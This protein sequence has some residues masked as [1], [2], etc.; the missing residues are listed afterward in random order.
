MPGIES[1]DSPREASRAALDLL[2]RKV[3]PS[4]IH[5]NADNSVP[6]W[7]AIDE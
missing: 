1:H 3:K 6:V 2:R 4:G 5:I 7:R